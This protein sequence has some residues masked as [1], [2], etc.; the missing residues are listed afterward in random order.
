[1]SA[2]TRKSRRFVGCVP[3]P[4]PP[5][6]AVSFRVAGEDEELGALGGLFQLPS[7]VS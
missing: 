6:G 7:A 3:L 1:M 5:V 2:H 4:L